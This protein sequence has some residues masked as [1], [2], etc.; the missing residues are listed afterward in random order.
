MKSGGLP[1]KNHLSKLTMID[2]ITLLGPHERYLLLLGDGSS[3]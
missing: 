3:G 2:E 1:S